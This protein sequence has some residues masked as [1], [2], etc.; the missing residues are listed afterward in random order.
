[1]VKSLEHLRNGIAAAAAI[2]FLTLPLAA[3]AAGGPSAAGYPLALMV[4]GIGSLVCHQ[5]PD[6]SFHLWAAALPVC[7]RCTGLYA[8]AAGAA[9]AALV[10]RLRVTSA[11]LLVMVL[12][13][14]VTIAYEWLTG[15]DPGNLARAA[16]GVPLGMAVI[17]L[18]LSPFAERLNE[19]PMG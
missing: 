7:A 5:R 3:I 1:M 9:G 8:G 16:A 17:A 18:V 15:V 11:A 2:W 19:L 14:V 4:Y 6:R 13:T 12:P 10:K